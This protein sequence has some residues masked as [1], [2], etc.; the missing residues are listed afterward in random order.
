MSANTNKDSERIYHIERKVDEILTILK[1]GGYLCPGHNHPVPP[2]P[3]E[4]YAEEPFTSGLPRVPLNTNPGG[5][6]F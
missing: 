2:V 3:Y 5:R 1:Q 6:L 4:F